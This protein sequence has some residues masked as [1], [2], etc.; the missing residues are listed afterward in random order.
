MNKYRTGFQGELGAFSEMAVQAYFGD[1]AEPVPHGWFDDVF[2]AVEE[3]R[4]DYGMLPIENTLAGSIHVNYDLMQEHNQQIV[5]EI[6]LRIV[7]NL[8]AKP[9]VRPEELRRVQSHTKALEQCVRFF[10]EH[11]SLKPETVYDTGGAAKMLGEGE[12]RDIGVIASTR[13]AERYGL[14]ILERG[15]EDNVQNYTRFLVLG[16]EPEP[17]VGERLKTSIVFSMPHEPGTLFKAMSVFAL[18]DISINKIESRPLVGSP[19]EYLFY[20]DFEGHADS[21]LCKRALNHLQ[22]IATNFKLLGSY[23]EGSIV[24]RV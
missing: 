3:G 12:D 18:R 8:M 5:G 22:E 16:R 2:R 4:C 17:P 1:A 24:D 10:R 15:I 6:V 7:H 14:E 19:W 13:A 11:P 20:L 21:L 23:A 9:G